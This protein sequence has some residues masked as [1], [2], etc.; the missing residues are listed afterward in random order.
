MRAILDRLESSSAVL[1]TDD[2]QELIVPKKDLPKSAH[3]GSALFLLFSQDAS[4]EAH[5]E[6]LAKSILNE[7]LKTAP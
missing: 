5:R 6:K 1:R 4:E 3:E 7:I 2:G